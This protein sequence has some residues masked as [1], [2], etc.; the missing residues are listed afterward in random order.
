MVSKLTG[1]N[2]ARAQPQWMT[3]DVR[4]DTVTLVRSVGGPDAAVRRIFQYRRET[5]R[6][7][8]GGS[9]VTIQPAVAS[10]LN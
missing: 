4:R 2:H 9:S 6:L 5:L 10:Y 8:D 1:P 7:S 3:E